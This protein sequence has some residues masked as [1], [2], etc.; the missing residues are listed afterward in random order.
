MLSVYNSAIRYAEFGPSAGSSLSRERMYQL[1]VS[2]TA[3]CV[4]LEIGHTRVLNA[5]LHLDFRV[6]QCSKLVEIW[7]TQNGTKND[8][9]KRLHSF[10]DSYYRAHHNHPQPAKLRQ[11]PN[12]VCEGV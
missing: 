8:P 11:T 3:A 12:G 10:A 2:S 4:S 1:S 9:P 5:G 7:G 6:M